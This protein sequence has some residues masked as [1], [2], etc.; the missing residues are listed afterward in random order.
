MKTLIKIALTL[1]LLSSVAY[2]EDSC[3]EYGKTVQ[4]VQTLR[5]QGNS[6]SAV[7]DYIVTLVEENGGGKSMVELYKDSVTMVYQSTAMTDNPLIL[8]KIAVGMC[9]KDVAAYRA[10]KK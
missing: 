1:T 4:A 10:R 6:L 2:A 7:R 8:N 3:E 5:Q 9:R